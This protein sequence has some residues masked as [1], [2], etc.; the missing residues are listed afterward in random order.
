MSVGASMLVKRTDHG[1]QMFVTGAARYAQQ[2][3]DLDAEAALPVRA[4]R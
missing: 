1:D 2:V 3:L 4:R